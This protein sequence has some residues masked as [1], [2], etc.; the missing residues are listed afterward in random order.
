MWLLLGAFSALLL[1][2]Y[3]VAKKVSL[4]KNA[5]IPVLFSSIVISCLI[6]SP[7]PVLSHYFPD[8]MKGTLLYVPPMDSRAHFYILLKSLLVLSSWLF[9]YFAMKHLPITIVTP[10]EATR[11]LWTLLGALII[12]SERLSPYQ[13]IGVSVT[14]ISFYLFSMVG[15]KEGVVFHHNKWVFFIILAALTGAASGLYDKFLMREFNRVGVQVYY[16]FYQAIIMGII[17][18][19][20]WYPKRKTSTPFQWRYSIIGISVFLTLAD[21]VYFF[22]LSDPNAMISLLSTVRRAGVVVSFSIGAFVFREKN[23]KIKF[24]CLA[25]VIAGTLIL[26]LGK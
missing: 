21:F 13:W 1:G 14:L 18:L 26:L 5:V 23:I 22:A 15:K 6:L 17:T 24:I 25:G 8:M 9:G 20:L 10:I 2:I 7:L 11:P 16:L 12:F 3:D 4:Q 19:F